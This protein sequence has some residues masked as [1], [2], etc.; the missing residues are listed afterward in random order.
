MGD[1]MYKHPQLTHAGT[2]DTFWTA[3]RPPDAQQ[4]EGFLLQIKNLTQAPASV[5]AGRSVPLA[6]PKRRP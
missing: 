1:S 4:A 3:A 6:W 5:Y 2:L